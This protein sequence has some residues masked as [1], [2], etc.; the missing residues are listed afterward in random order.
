MATHAKK[1][2]ARKHRDYAPMLSNKWLKSIGIGIILIFGIFLIRA[3]TP[4]PA[5]ANFGAQV[6]GAPKI[7]V[8]KDT[9]D[10]GYIKNGTTV[11]VMFR[12]RNM[13]DQLLKILN[14]PRVEVVEGCCPP[15]AEVSSS[16]IIPGDESLI[17]LHFMMHDGMDGKHLF[18]VHVPTN[19]PVQPE[20]LLLVYSNWGP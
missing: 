3:N 14:E 13:G 12:V 10:L 11:E 15:R 7:G 1:F 20:K 2:R 17:K 4:A 19:D 8:D 9:V 16:Q 5:P 6:K 18:R